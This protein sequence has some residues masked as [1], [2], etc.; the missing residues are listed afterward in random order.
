MAWIDERSALAQVYARRA[1]F[2]GTPLWRDDG[3]IIVTT[4]QRQWLPRIVR[5]SD[6]GFIV[7]FLLY[8]D[9]GG[10]YRPWAQRI[11]SS[12]ATTWGAGGVPWARRRSVTPSTSWPTPPAVPPPGPPLLRATW[13]SSPSIS[14][15]VVL[16]SGPWLA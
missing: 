14:R 1:G 11:S 10:P 7:S 8:Q 9:G 2:F 6:G 16:A 5:T 12:G 4:Y 15:P 13:T 3:S